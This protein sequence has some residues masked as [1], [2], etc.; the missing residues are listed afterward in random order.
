MSAFK[1]TGE[2]DAQI[3]FRPFIVNEYAK[4]TKQNK[5]TAKSVGFGI[6]NSAVTTDFSNN[7]M[8]AAEAAWAITEVANAL[9]T[10]Q[11]KQK[12]H[13]ME[14]FKQMMAAMG[15]GNSNQNNNQNGCNQAGGGSKGKPCKHCKFKHAKPD[16]KCWELKANAASRLANWK[17]VT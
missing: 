11:D 15:K 3:G 16:A 6:A 5:S 13:M 17:P 12:E 7:D 8:Q 2:Y 1:G 4:Q 14:M 10:A 9:Q